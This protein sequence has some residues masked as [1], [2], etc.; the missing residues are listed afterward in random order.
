M[1]STIIKYCVI[2]RAPFHPDRRV[3]KRQLVCGKTECQLQR[4]KQ[5]RDRWVEKNPDYFTGRY[6][7]LKTQIQANKK[8]KA[9]SK[10]QPVLSIQDDLT[11][12]NYNLLNLLANISSIQDDITHKITIGNLQFK[13]SLKL[14]YKTN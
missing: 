9:L 3:E 5:S 10:K 14:V 12:N 2:C 13:S 8:K 6:Q 7:E 11:L 4:K 1:K